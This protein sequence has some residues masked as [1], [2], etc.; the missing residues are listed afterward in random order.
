MIMLQCEKLLLP[1]VQPEEEAWSCEDV[2]HK[3]CS[4]ILHACPG[5]PFRSMYSYCQRSKD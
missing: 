4:G 3:R 5:L 2:L 1:C